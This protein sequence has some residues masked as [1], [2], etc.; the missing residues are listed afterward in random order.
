MLSLT[1]NQ[2]ILLLDIYRDK[3]NTQGL[4]H[5]YNSDLVILHQHGLIDSITRKNVTH[6]GI[7]LVNKIRKISA[8][9]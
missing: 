5:S 2:I 7:E 4:N 3:G 8:I 1:M 6:K 9:Y